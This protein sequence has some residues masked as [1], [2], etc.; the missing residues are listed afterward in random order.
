MTDENTT[1][2]L[3]VAGGFI[4]DRVIADV[5]AMALDG[6]VN[7]NLNDHKVEFTVIEVPIPDLGDDA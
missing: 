2:F 4:K 5:M 3:I 7:E 1:G 6:I